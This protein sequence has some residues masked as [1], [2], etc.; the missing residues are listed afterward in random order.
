MTEMKPLLD[1]S[2]SAEVERLLR[3]AESDGPASPER[4]EAQTLAA[5]GALPSTSPKPTAAKLVAS[6]GR[7]GALSAIAAV[8]VFSAVVAVR[9]SST[10][11]HAPSAPADPGTR[12]L[13]AA[14][15]AAPIADGVRVEDL[16]TVPNIPKL[17]SA[18]G[19]AKPAPRGPSSGPKVGA[20]Y[21]LEDEL[22]PIDAARAALGS[23]HPDVALAHVHG[24]QRTFHDGRFAE[25][26]DALE[27]QALA[28]L[29]RRTEARTKGERFLTSHPGSPYEQRVR[30]SIA[31][32]EVK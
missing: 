4:A 17:A 20:R 29:G 16:P 13:L 10:E 2:A 28:A 30:S 15:G 11:R 25:E 9:S 7:A 18:D 3:S 19:I 12:E 1:E 22:A 32:D 8:A 24:Y 14:E 31:S 23:G 26:A 27:I 21:G 6:L 5:I